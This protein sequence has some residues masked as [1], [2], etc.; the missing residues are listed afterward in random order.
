MQHI[1]ITG[2]SAFSSCI[3]HDWNHLYKSDRGIV[4]TFSASKSPEVVLVVFFLVFGQYII[5][6][7]CHQHRS[8]RTCKIRLGI[9]SWLLVSSQDLH[10]I[11]LILVLLLV[12]WVCCRDWRVPGVAPLQILLE[13]E[14][15]RESEHLAVQWVHYAKLEIG[16]ISLSLVFIRLDLRCPRMSADCWI[17][18]SSQNSIP[19]HLFH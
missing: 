18:R 6:C 7:W 4:G 2:L 3:L 13:A 17:I 19:Y 9:V 15:G 1:G 10:E 16:S 14:A 5:F 8:S 12:A 11:A